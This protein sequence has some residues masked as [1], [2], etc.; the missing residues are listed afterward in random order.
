VKKGT[1]PDFL[2]HWTPQPACWVLGSSGQLLQ[3]LM[4]LIQNAYDAAKGHTPTPELWITLSQDP[5]WARIG[6]RDNG[7]GIPP[8]HLGKLFDPFFTT[9]PVGQ[10]TGLGLSISFGAVEQHGGV[11]KGANAPEGGAVFSLSLPVM[12]QAGKA[13]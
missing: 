2:I 5:A 11:L 3:V 1:A 8:E 12:P 9:K 4:N 10:G 6:L 13:G 7:P